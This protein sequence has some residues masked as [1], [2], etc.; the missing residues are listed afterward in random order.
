MAPGFAPL[1]NISQQALPTP[2]IHHPSFLPRLVSFL[3]DLFANSDL[4]C[5]LSIGSKLQFDFGGV[6]VFPAPILSAV[7]WMKVEGS[8]GGEEGRK[9]QKRELR[10]GEANNGVK[11][12]GKRRTRRRVQADSTTGIQKLFMVCKKV[13]KGPG[14]VPEPAEVDMLQQL[15]GNSLNSVLIPFVYNLLEK[16]FCYWRVYNWDHNCNELVCFSLGLTKQI[17]ILLVFEV[18]DY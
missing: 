3:F 7:D 6:F 15:L 14:T 2:F 18:I 17:L 16:A 10:N 13:F 12:R 8:T 1:Y 9:V 5:F 4:L 11:L